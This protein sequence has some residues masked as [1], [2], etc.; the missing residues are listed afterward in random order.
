MV[1]KFAAVKSPCKQNIFSN[2]FEFTSGLIL[3]EPVCFCSELFLL[4]LDSIIEIRGN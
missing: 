2:K 3:V 1:S 4:L